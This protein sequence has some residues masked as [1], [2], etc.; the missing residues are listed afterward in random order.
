M[1]KLTKIFT[2]IM[3]L[4]LAMGC[5][6][7][8][9]PEITGIEIEDN[10]LV[11]VDDTNPNVTVYLSGQGSDLKSLE[12]TVTSTAG[13]A[14]VYSNKLTHI[15]HDKLKR[16]KLNIP[17]PTPDIAPSG[18]YNV[19]FKV[20]D[21]ENVVYE[22]KVL[23]NRSIKYCDF[24]AVPSGKVG[25]FV[26]VPD[27]DRL[28]SNSVYI[29]GDF[30]TDNGAPGDW[31]PGN[32]DFKLTKLGDD[33]YYIF[34][35]SFPAGSNYKLTLGDWSNEFLSNT[36]GGMDNQV[37]TS[38]NSVNIIAHNFKTIPVNQYEIPEVLPT[39]AIKSG[40]TTVIM[41]VGTVAEDTKYY[42]VKENAASLD[43]AIEMSRVV[44]TNKFAGAVPRVEGDKYK[45]VKNELTKVAIGAFG[46]ERIATIDLTTNPM[47]IK[48]AAGFKPD[49]TPVTVTNLFVTGD[50]VGG[51][52]NPVNTTTNQFATTGNGIFTLTRAF[53]ANQG[54]LILLQNGS[55]DFKIGK[56]GSGT[57]LSGTAVYGGGDFTSPAEAGTYTMTVNLNTETYTLVKQ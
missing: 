45:V 27:G 15:T 49:Y 4:F 36:G 50:A 14:T 19:A 38:G 20:N 8:L 26:S 2:L 37:Y 44:G 22:V 55:W 30:M 53:T 12:V 39:A 3:V 57:A 29:V 47:V 11:Q 52:N 6:D 1:N 25:I 16:V 21:T 28:G 40:T 17:F 10:D 41:D 51:W 24:P 42:L 34:L 46:S 9:S 18:T 5:E 32:A 54:Y 48:K 13:G 23:N 7:D 31:N 43:G 35:N 56:D 33:C